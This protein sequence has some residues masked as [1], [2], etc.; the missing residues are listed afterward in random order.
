MRQLANLSGLVPN[1]NSLFMQIIGLFA[2]V[3]KPQSFWIGS[4]STLFILSVV[5]IKNQRQFLAPGLKFTRNKNYSQQ[6]KCKNV[7]LNF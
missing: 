7:F 6:G 5:V 4:L 3:S 2:T 1:L